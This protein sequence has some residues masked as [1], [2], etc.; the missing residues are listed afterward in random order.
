MRTV[1]KYVAAGLLCLALLIPCAC[2]PNGGGTPVDPVETPS[3][4]QTPEDTSS[5]QPS[6]SPGPSGPVETQE[7]NPEPTVSGDVPALHPDEETELFYEL[8]GETHSVAAVRH[9]TLHGYTIVYD[10]MHYECRSYH[11]VDSYWSDEGLY[12]SVSIVYGMPM[13]YVLD[14]LQLQE[15]IEMAAEL[16]FIGSDRCTAY[17][18]YTTQNG[19]FR[20]FWALDYAGDTMLIER[21]FPVEHEYADFHRAVQDAMLDT[22]TLDAPPSADAEADPARVAYT[23]AL[24]NLYYNRVFPDGTAADPTDYFGSIS[25]NRFAIYDIDNDGKEELILEYTNTMVAGMS[26]Q[27][28]GYDEAAHALRLQ[29]WE[30]PNA[31]FF[32]NGV[33][34]AGISHNQGLAGAF[35]PYELYVPDAAADRYVS[36]GLVT[37]WDKAVKEADFPNDIDVD[38]DG[39]VYYLPTDPDTPVDTEDYFRWRSLYLEN[40]QPILLPYQFLTEE[41]IAAI[42]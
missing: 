19:L 4:S 1:L 6:V 31:Q 13:D 32:D 27:I 30:F 2:V 12:L 42:Q 38:G 22:L 18:L 25:D 17:T 9:H 40:A 11:E 3:A 24:E 10:A 33:V 23:T 16:A 39:I 29:L 35:W 20:Q 5:P 21:S 8:N 15:N 34:E 28:Y 36:V 7:P 14:G 26:L 37:A 41:N